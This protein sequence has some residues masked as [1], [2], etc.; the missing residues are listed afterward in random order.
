MR[1]LVTRLIERLPLNSRERRAVEET[2]ADW[3]HE[4][5][6]AWSRSARARVAATG[7]LAVAS[8]VSRPM[9]RTLF[10]W[11]ALAAGVL[12]LAYLV[13][14]GSVAIRWYGDF[15]GFLVTMVLG[16]ILM[17]ALRF[18]FARDHSPVTVFDPFARETFAT[19]AI[20]FA[21]VRVAGLGGAGLVLAAMVAA[22][23]FQLTTVALGLGLCG[24]I[25][26][27]TTVI[28]FRR[29]RHS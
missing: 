10:R 21:H 19:D 23:E 27:G 25:L 29:W 18:G 16:G 15:E 14:F 20:N 3:Q 1:R 7:F 28:L 9:A 5:S 26:G 17:A 8:A 6:L 24:G 4:E 11:V 13:L 12:A 22:L 2:F